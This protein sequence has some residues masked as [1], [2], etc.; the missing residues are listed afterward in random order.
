LAGSTRSSTICSLR[1]LRQR[2]LDEI[3]GAG[4]VGVQVVDGRL[5][6]GLGGV[7]RQIAPDRHDAHVGAV[8]VFAVDVGPGAGIIADEDRPQAR[9][10]PGVRQRLHP[11]PQLILDRR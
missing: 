3:A 10:V 2:Q 8:A 5:D 1:P 9:S 6:V 7:G 11:Y 4:R